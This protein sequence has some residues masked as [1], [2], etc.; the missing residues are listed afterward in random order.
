MDIRIKPHRLEGTVKIPSSKSLT[1]RAVIC[2][3]L[4]DGISELKNISYSKDI[5]ATITAM[6][7]MG[8][9]I[10]KHGSSLVVTGISESAERME[11]ECCESGSTL[12]FLIPIAAALGANAVF[13]GE[14]RLPERPIT[15][16]VRELPCKGIKLDYHNTMPFSISG[17]LIGGDFSL[18]GDVSSQFVTGL[19]MALP[20]LKDDSRIIMTS[21]L[22][23]KP[24]AD[25]TV[26]CLEK[27]GITVEET[28]YGYFIK[29]GQKYSPCNMPVEGDYSQAAFFLVGNAIGNR[30]Q[31]E[32]LSENSVQ[33]DKKIVDIISNICY[34]EKYEK[35]DGFDVD[36][37]DIPDLVPAL[38]VLASF[39]K[40]K[41]RIYGAERLKIKE[42]DR[43][44]A[45]SNML[46]GL[47]GK[48]T[49][50]SDGL[51][52]EPVS[53]LD[54]GTVDS[55]GDHRIAMAAAIASTRCMNDV[56]IL[57]ADSVEKSYPSFFDDFKN[58]GGTA[59]VIN[60]E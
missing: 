33:G 14:G 12:R 35:L 52:I 11:I 29:G 31:L 38:A 6:R 18:E 50:L 57:N 53:M 32:N 25:M 40:S 8:A 55:C 3:A 15:P 13:Y 41:S 28:E 44:A 22:Q 47:G 5:D 60:L 20:L 7:N 21:P 51:I 58:I 45:V 24:Y 27:F 36:V 59:D 48:V 17:Q 10:E 49:A 30:I 37:T 16:Y 42:S 43:L 56:V 9:V 39:C 2:A 23:S 19:L 4:A 46:N 26:S 1:H 54:G 34:N